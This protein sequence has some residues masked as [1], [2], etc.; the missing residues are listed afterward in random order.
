M[1]KQF[2]SKPKS[3]RSIDPRMAEL[4]RRSMQLCYFQSI[5]EC[6]HTKNKCLKFWNGYSS[7]G[8][9]FVMPGN[10]IKEGTINSD[11]RDFFSNKARRINFPISPMTKN[12]EFW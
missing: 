10:V 9:F 8:R 1:F 6:D 5:V 2:R 12:F 7:D 11:F 3:K 4:L